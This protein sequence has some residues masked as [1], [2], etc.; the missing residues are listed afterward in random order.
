MKPLSIALGIIL[1]L[2]FALDFIKHKVLVHLPEK[3]HVG[4]ENDVQFA[5]IL[6]VAEACVLFL[7]VFSLFAPAQSPEE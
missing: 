7:F 1:A 6:H 4:S 5:Q 2:L 3:W